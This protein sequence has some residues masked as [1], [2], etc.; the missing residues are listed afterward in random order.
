MEQQAAHV[1]HVDL[2][3]GIGHQPPKDAAGQGAHKITPIPCASVWR[4]FT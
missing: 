4:I 3:E 1:Q 2:W